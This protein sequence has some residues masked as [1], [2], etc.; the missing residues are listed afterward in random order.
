[1]LKNNLSFIFRLITDLKH[2]KHLMMNMPN[3]DLRLLLV[4]ELKLGHNAS[5]TFTNINR[6][7][8]EGSTCNGTVQ[9]WFLNFCSGDERLLE[10]EKSGG[11]ACS[12]GNEQL[13]AIIE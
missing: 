11:Q 4:Y 3:H 9:M 2:T 6:E 8:E 5:E 7:W 12:L 1:M 10:D 13:Q